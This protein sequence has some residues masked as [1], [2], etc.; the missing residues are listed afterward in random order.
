MLISNTNP[1][2]GRRELHVSSA[3]GDGFTRMARL[4]IPSPRPATLQY[5]HAVEH[6]GHLYVTFSRNKAAIEVVRVRVA[7][8][9][10]ARPGK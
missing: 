2:V 6:G 10:P 4:G 8:V 3:D 1:K 7:D 9:Q 5:P